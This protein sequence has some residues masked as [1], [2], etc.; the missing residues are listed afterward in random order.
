MPATTVFERRMEK[1]LEANTKSMFAVP[2][3]DS[4]N[5]AYIKGQRVGLEQAQ[6]FYRDEVRGIDSED[7]I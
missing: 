3:G 2:L 1:A 6:G 5:H 4:H 7:G